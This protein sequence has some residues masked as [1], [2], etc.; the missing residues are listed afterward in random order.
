MNKC[1][2]ILTKY[3][4]LKIYIDGCSKGNPGEGACAAIIMNENGEIIAEEGR[5]LGTCTNNF[6]EYSSLHLA[7][8]VARRYNAKR[9]KIYSDSQ[10]LVKQYNGEYQ[11]KDEKLKEL[12]DII[13]KEARN[14]ETVEV[15]YIPRKQN[16]VADR[17]VNKLIKSKKLNKTDR[18]KLNKEREKRFKQDTLF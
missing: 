8:S 10:L 15:N 4:E 13:K 1:K 16:S 11:I 5:V 3:N 18:E 12:M 7:L 2:K 9:L 14:F 6:A 17:F